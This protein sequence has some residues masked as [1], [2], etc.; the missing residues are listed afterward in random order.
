MTEGEIRETTPESREKLFHG[1]KKLELTT[2][3]W[4]FDPE[5]AFALA[6]KL[7]SETPLKKDWVSIEIYPTVNPKLLELA[8]KLGI[9]VVGKNTPPKITPEFVRELQKTYPRTEVS[10]V[11]LEFS[12]D[13][14]ETYFHRP[15]IGENL[16]PPTEAIKQRIFQLAWIFLFGPATSRR[17]IRLAEELGVGINAH[18]NVLEGFAKRG[19]IEDIKNKVAFVLAETERPYNSP[20]LQRLKKQGISSRQFASDPEIVK[21]EIVEKYGLDGL[22]L[23]VDHLIQLG[24]D[25]VE[26]LEKTA[27]AVR[28][29]HLAGGQGAGAHELISQGDPKVVEFL[30]A[31]ARQTFKGEVSAALDL[32]P[33]LMKTMPFETQLT[34]LRDTFNWLRKS[35]Q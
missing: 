16:T 8:K 5:R 4:L 25:P 13:W 30:E 31:A 32:N 12:F 9:P 15:T 6:D 35:Q 24:M 11:H 27:D 3:G 33:V 20:H 22:L 34:V 29:I 21:K 10:R 26:K 1:I 19:E 7:N 23:G 17:G 2:S 18:P 28:A 14:F